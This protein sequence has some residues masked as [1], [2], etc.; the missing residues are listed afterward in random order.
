[1]NGSPCK[2]RNV[3]GSILGLPIYGTHINFETSSCVLGHRPCIV[4]TPLMPVDGSG[5][6]VGS[7]GHRGELGDMQFRHAFNSE[8]LSVACPSFCFSQT[9]V[10]RFLLRGWV[11]RALLF[12]SC[13]YASG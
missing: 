4:E 11:S 10:D 9:V 6:M 8:G 12:V 2:E 7:L 3:L 13:E 5:Y 1:M